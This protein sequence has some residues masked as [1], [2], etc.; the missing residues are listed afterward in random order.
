MLAL[1]GLLISWGIGLLISGA[2][3]M[4]FV[5]ALDLLER[6]ADNTARPAAATP[7]VERPRQGIEPAMAEFNDGLG[8]MLRKDRPAPPR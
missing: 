4:G 2:T 7:A 3:M 1:N 5:R 8:A 6:I